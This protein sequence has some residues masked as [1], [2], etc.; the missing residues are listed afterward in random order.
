L[1]PPTPDSAGLLAQLAKDAADQS[2]NCITVDGDTSTN[3]SFV[4][5]A[6][7]A[8]GSRSMPPRRTGRRC[9]MR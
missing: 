7:G 2:F 9:A 8:A 4:V 5:I 6:T 1:S 3:D